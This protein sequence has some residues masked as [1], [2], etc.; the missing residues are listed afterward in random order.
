[1]FESN[2]FGMLKNDLVMIKKQIQHLNT[3]INKIL[4][5][6]TLWKRW[7]QI[8]PLYRTNLCDDEDDLI[9]F[10][11]ALS[12]KMRLSIPELPAYVIMSSFVTPLTSTICDEDDLIDFNQAFEAIY[13][14]F[15]PN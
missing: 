12:I 11:S 15:M 3:S 8:A 4:T 13:C 10:W 6:V 2:K 7:R 1:M 5:W 14:K 9:W